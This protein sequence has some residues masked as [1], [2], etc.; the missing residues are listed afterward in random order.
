MKKFSHLFSNRRGNVAAPGAIFFVVILLLVGGTLDMMSVSNQKSSLQDLADNAALAAVNEL[1]ISAQDPAR[2]KAVAKAFSD[3]SDLRI[4]SVNTAVD[5]EQRQVTVAISAE[6]KTN[7]PKSMANLKSIE[8]TA[9]ARLSGRGGNICMIGLSPSAISTLRLMSRAQITADT[10]AIYSNST[11]T[12]SM[13]VASTAAVTADLIC[14]AGGYQGNTSDSSGSMLE[15]CSPVS[16][17]LA[18]RDGPEVGTCDF[19]NTVIRNGRTLNPGVYCGGLIVDGGFARLNSG[20]YIVTGGPLKV[21][22]NGTLEGEYV[23][24][25]LSGTD[26]KIQFDYDSNIAISAPKEGI[27]TG[28]LLYSSPYED[29]VQIAEA[30][31][32]TRVSGGQARVSGAQARVNTALRT[33]DGVTKEDHYIRSDNAR[34]LV[35]TIYLPNGKLLIDGRRPIADR[36]EYTVIIADTFELQDGPNLVLR[37][38]YHLSDIPVPE[39]V[40][41]MEEKQARLVN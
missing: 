28:L 8:S 21:T 6:P 25:Y 2:A 3:K 34:R 9:T 19:T 33:R 14:V 22:N 29:V 15:D 39:G 16:D 31:S 23:G 37:T 26:A 10:C 36:S 30:A 38:D 11:S 41:P 20:E 18:M 5:L 12:A 4:L 27:M 17:P 13:W 35:G 24:F 1:A 7:F 32:Y 40:G